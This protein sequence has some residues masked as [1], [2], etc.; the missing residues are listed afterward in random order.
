MSSSSSSSS[1]KAKSSSSST[2][3]SSLVEALVLHLDF[4]SASDGM[5]IT[6]D[7]SDEDNDAYD[8][9]GASGL[10]GPTWGA[11]YGI[12][13]G[14]VS[15]SADASN[16]D[17]LSISS[18]SGLSSM[19]RGSFA[20][21]IKADASGNTDSV[22]MSL[23]NG[24]LSTK[25]EFSIGLNRSTGVLS[26]WLTVDGV[27]QWT[28]ASP[29]GTIT[30]GRWYHVAVSHSGASPTILVDGVNTA[31]SFST[32]V[33]KTAW[34]VELYAASSPVDRLIIGG[35]T[36]HT[37][38]YVALGFSGFMDEVKIWNTYLSPTDLQDAYESESSS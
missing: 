2:S 17:F 38:P 7:L 21:W 3:S 25:T 35:A 16:T 20:T 10:G 19:T 22:L 8:G 29:T 12:A 36:R 28:L 23:S 31:A 11:A 1:V 5:G 32:N 9:S 37:S 26:A 4:T 30:T 24:Y 13:G 15:F 18:P 33:D 14:G 6:Y 34:L 27:N